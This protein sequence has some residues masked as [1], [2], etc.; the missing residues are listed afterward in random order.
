MSRTS[1][2]SHQAPPLPA[3]SL[4]FIQSLA[5]RRARDSSGLFYADGV[6]FLVAAADAGIPIR[7]LVT[8]PRILKSTIGQMLV[9]RLR[10]RGVPELRVAPEELAALSH[11]PSNE[12]QGVG[13]VMRQTWEPWASQSAEHATCWLALEEVRSP[14]NLGTL[15]RTSEA[16]GSTGLLAL[17]S[18]IDPFDPGCV[19][20][21]MGALFT[22]RLARA[23]PAEL[24]IWA[25]THDVLVV[26]AT[27]DATVDYRDISYSRPVV[28]VLGA[29]R[30]GL[31]PA[32]RSACDITV[33]IP[34][35]GRT[36]SLNLA[37][38][39]SVLLY[40]VYSQRHP[41]PSPRK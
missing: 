32:A 34:M 18:K 27:G 2:G 20:A 19:R 33:R 11:A 4:P 35:V 25:K 6:R 39:G 41:R 29:E 21:T 7:G 30:K 8:S 26:G 3:L 12:P 38:A 5:S 16:T 36:D 15:L 37:V 13:V 22:R 1:T 28:L 9:R 24:A 10:S 40:E 14:G 17:G 23:T 31:S